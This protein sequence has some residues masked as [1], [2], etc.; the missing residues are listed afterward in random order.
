LSSFHGFGLAEK[1][2]RALADAKYVVRTPI[3]KQIFQT[4][5]NGQD[6]S[7]YGA[8]VT[9]PNL[10]RVATVS[11][12][13]SARGAAFLV[14]QPGNCQRRYSIAFGYLIGICALIWHSPSAACR[15]ET[16]SRA[17]RLLIAAL[18][19]LLDLLNSDAPRMSAW[20]SASCSTRDLFVTS[21]GEYTEQP[22]ALFL[23]ASMLPAIAELAGQ[24][25]NP[26]KISVVPVAASEEH[27]EQRVGHLN[28]AVRPT[29]F[30]QREPISRVLAFS[31]TKRAFDKV[32][33]ILF[34]LGTSAQAVEGN[35]SQSQRLRVVAAFRS[36]QRPAII[37][38]HA[39]FECVVRADDSN[40]L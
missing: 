3:Q 25:R 18:R 36:G 9:L 17:V 5:M 29:E 14:R 40:W 35:K 33:R 21:C 6:F 32:V 37:A 4:V 11:G 20:C 10:P 34:E 28:R 1:I 22:Q 23:S 15:W 30:L 19:G 39:D 13:A 2:A 24:M 12:Q 7:R 27:V 16:G 38:H 31:R 26:V 8:T